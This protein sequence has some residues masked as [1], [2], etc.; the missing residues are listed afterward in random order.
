[1]GH[2]PEG[3]KTNATEKGRYTPLL[4]LFLNASLDSH[5]TK[6]DSWQVTSFLHVATPMW[7]V[8]NIYCKLLF[9]SQF[10]QENKKTTY[11]C[12]YMII[13]LQTVASPLSHLLCTNS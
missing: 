4:S 5:R 13:W 6:P 1:M 2:I 12:T 9:F 3:P 11:V 10:N 8:E 7:H